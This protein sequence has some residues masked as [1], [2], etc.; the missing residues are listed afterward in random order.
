VCKTITIIINEKEV[1]CL[2]GR[3][4]GGADGKE[5]EGD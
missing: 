3:G 1:M 2:R 4:M 5:L